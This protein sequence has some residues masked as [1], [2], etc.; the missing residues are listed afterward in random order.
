MAH[1]G[2][3]GRLWL[4]FFGVLICI[5]CDSAPRE[6][7]RRNALQPHQGNLSKRGGTATVREPYERQQ[8]DPSTSNDES[9]DQPVG[10]FGTVT[11]IVFQEESGHTYTLDI[12]IEDSKVRRI[13]FPKGGWV[14][15]EGCEL[16]DDLTGDC[17]DESGRHWTFEGQIHDSGS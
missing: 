4:A 12:E 15:L 8:D 3:L 1:L 6:P 14:D 13:Y 16:D 7:S 11:M 10:H 2:N 5:G 9:N 17:E